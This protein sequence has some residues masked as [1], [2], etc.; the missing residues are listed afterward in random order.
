MQH[1][2]GGD[3][4]GATAFA[5]GLEQHPPGGNALARPEGQQQRPGTASPG[6]SSN[7]KRGAI[8]RFRRNARIGSAEHARSRAEFF[9]LT[10]TT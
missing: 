1:E 4:C 8:S 5:P 6:R 9:A 3:A 10:G 7:A 2:A